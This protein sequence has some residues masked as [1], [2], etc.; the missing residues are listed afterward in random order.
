ML[1]LPSHTSHLLQ[2][3]DVDVFKSLKSS[4][5]KACKQFMAPRPG[6][7][8]K[9]EDP[10]SL[11]AVARPHSVKPVN[12]MSGFRKCGIYPL[13]PGTI[14]D[15]LTAP[16]K[17]TSTPSP[18]KDICDS[19]HCSSSTG[20]TAGSGLTNLSPVANS[21]G[22][23]SA[24][25]TSSR[26]LHDV[27]ALPK[28]NT[29]T[30]CRCKGINQEVVCITNVSFVSEMEGKEIE[31][32]KEED[33]KRKKRIEREQRKEVW[34]EAKILKKATKKEDIEK[35]HKEGRGLG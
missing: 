12:I 25:S 22:G 34:E 28:L 14:D 20:S 7:V 35:S 32:Q 11:L 26:Y 10:A 3:L 6:S 18:S 17:V 1:C 27:L 9:S 16:S 19:S 15:R 24:L 23:G 30:A 21:E 29:T 5:N 13:N 8:V 33:E 2:P 4:F 31:K